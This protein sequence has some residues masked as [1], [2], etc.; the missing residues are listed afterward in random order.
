MLPLLRVSETID[1]VASTDS[2]V[3]CD[4]GPMRWLRPADC[5]RVKDDALIV[6]VRPMR[7]REVLRLQG[8]PASI[9]VDACLICVQRIRGQGID[10]ST[11]QGLSDLIDRIP[12]AELA[13]LGGAIFELSLSPPDPTDASA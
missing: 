1:L 13:T 3:L 5:E 9:S 7:S 2:A 4:A 12:P 10:E 6:T 8:D 11:A